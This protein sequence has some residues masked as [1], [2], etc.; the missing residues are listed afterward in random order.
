M[1]KILPGHRVAI[2]V[3]SRGISDIETVVRAVVGCVRHRGGMP[4]I[5]PAMGSHGGATADGQADVLS[6]YGITAESMGCEIRSS[7]ETSV[8][9]KTTHGVD[10]HVDS[11]AMAADHV[12]IVNRIKLHTRIAGRYQ[13]GII[14][15]MLIGLGKHRGAIAYHRAMAR[16]TFDGLVSQAA[17]MIMA[18]CPILMGVG[19]VENAFDQIA[20]IE[21]IPAANILQRE[22]QLLEIAR[23]HMPRLPFADA[24]LLMIDRIGKNISGSGLDTNVV[25]RKSND[26]AAAADEVPKVQLIYV[27]GLTPQT[28]GNASG[29]GIAEFC[30]SE[31]VREMD[32]DITRINCLTALHVSAAA[33]PVHYETDREVLRIA[34]DQ[35]GRERIRDV[36]CLWIEDTLHVAEVTCSEAYLEEAIAGGFEILSQPQTLEWK[37]DGNLALPQA[38]K[39]TQT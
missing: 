12:I 6:R 39:P 17:P 31:L 37:S 30:R 9:G 27:R 33:I 26:K 8:V 16:I 13:S 32:V 7:M 2:A 23:G 36:R 25:G 34:I 11:Y 3:G 1:A 14:K 15:M 21:A 24:D 5:I 22:P 20:T 35:C 28:K 10:V 29:I 4:F 38:C 19:I 18:S